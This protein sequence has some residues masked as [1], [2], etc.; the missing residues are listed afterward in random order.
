MNLPTQFNQMSRVLFWIFNGSLLL[1][2]YLGFLP[3]LAPAIIA[4][5]I[6]GKVPLNFLI[7]FV[8]LVGVPTTCTAIG[9]ISKPKRSISLFQL[10][11]SVEAPL[12]ILC[13]ARFF[14][15]RDLTPFTTVFLTSGLLGTLAFTH[16]L[17][18]ARG[19]NSSNANWWHL[20]GQTVMLAIAL[21]FLT[22]SAFY[23]VPFISFILVIL[24][25]LLYLFPLGIIMI[26]F[27]TLP[28][29]MAIAY[30]LAWKQNLKQLANR[31]GNFLVGGFIVAVLAGW[32]GILIAVAHQPQ[33]Q[34]FALLQT[35]AQT[36]QARQALVQK[37][38]AI[39]RGLLNAYLAKYRY[40][41]FKSDR[42]IYDIY[43]NTFAF[44]D[45]S[46]QNLQNLYSTLTA[47]FAYQG[48]E[49]DE[50]KA[51]ELYAQFFDTPIMRAELAAI[52]KALQST[53]NRGEAKAGLLDINE[54]RVWLA[55]QEIT[56]KPQGNW[57]DVELYE[58]YRNQTLDQEEILYYFSLPESAVVTG[59]WLGETSDRAKRYVF[60]IAPRGAAQE[61][62]NNE[63]SR[64][65]DPALLE[66]VGPHQYRLRAFPIPPLGQGEMHLWLTYKVLKQDSGWALPELLERRNIFWTSK[67]KR[68][69]D[70][71]T[72]VASDRWLPATLSAK[73]A[74]AVSHEVI[75]PDGDRVLAKPFA[76]SY[77]LPQNKRF[78]II[79]DG[80]YSMNRHRQETIETFRWLKDNVLKHNQADLYLTA[81]KPAQPKRLDSLQE[82]AAN[83]ATFYGTL[84][85]KEM[86]EQFLALRGD[87]NYDAILF[88]TDSGSYELTQDSKSVL[89]MPAPLWLVHLG[90]LQPAYDDAT[91]QAIQDSGGG[92]ATQVQEVVRR[93][94]TQPSLGESAIN[95]VDGYAWFLEKASEPP[96][97]V[98]GF[99][100]IAARQW[101][102][103]LSRTTKPDD[104]RELDAIHAI[105]KQ[106][107]IVTPYSSAI[108]L[109]NDRQQEA[110]RQAEQRS[111]RFQREIEDQQLPSPSSLNTIS[112]VPE[113]AEW[114]LILAGA[115]CLW[116]VYQRQK[117]Q[118]G[119]D[120]A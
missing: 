44:S 85:P 104:V 23:A 33:H 89:Q 114:L 86:L 18:S 63:V 1:I 43:R 80:S 100:P 84:Q 36:E 5:A 45:R 42:H 41:W 12:L 103:R 75:L 90:G 34:A 26:G 20:A 24:I 106:Y 96:S 57:A 21:Y 66:Q 10:F 7:P 70:G 46:A 30:L 81:T 35:P 40:P 92:V 79:L 29:G 74:Q 60:Q 14:W 91:L 82:F 28:I 78:A 71:K 11:Y 13:L 101:I 62:Y 72:V 77:R 27:G 61:V 51:A 22:I 65:V 67:T 95:L 15:L 115:I 117:Q 3:F 102:A 54:E 88:L 116:F 47:P 73:N 97:P 107:E 16:W 64:R 113:P 49:A 32:M 69:V 118:R 108:V 68:I 17:L 119:C 83:K 25:I 99:S 4:D 76:S 93:L 2:V 6:A 87:R 58:V 8:G 53:F 19:S 120:S 112:A 59:M 39:R 9:A 50:A 98:E 94:G 37:S 31:H 48:T 56:V 52:Q 38:E 110:L 111:D 109:V 55:Q 105:A